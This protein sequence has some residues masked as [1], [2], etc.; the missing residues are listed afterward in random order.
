MAFKLLTW[1]TNPYGYLCSQVI[2][3]SM[4]PVKDDVGSE[5][6]DAAAGG[7][8]SDVVEQPPQTKDSKASKAELKDWL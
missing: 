2:I 5:I 7:I 3:L 1:V 8:G 4:F 6:W